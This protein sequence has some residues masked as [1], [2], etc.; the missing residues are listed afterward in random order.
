MNNTI[1][2]TKGKYGYFLTINGFH[3]KR[4]WENEILVTRTNYP[5]SNWVASEWDS[6]SSLRKFWNNYRQI[7]LNKTK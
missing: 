7:I 4:S 6:L 2:I 5:P 1:E 3:I